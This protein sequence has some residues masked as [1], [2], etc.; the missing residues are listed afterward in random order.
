MPEYKLRCAT[1]GRNR[2][3]IMWQRVNQSHVAAGRISISL[4][5][6]ARRHRDWQP[7]YPGMI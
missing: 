6:S 4:T 2:W 7:R 5:L 1:K 3:G